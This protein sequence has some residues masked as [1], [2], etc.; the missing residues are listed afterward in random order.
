MKIAS[1]CYVPPPG[2]G[3]SNV[4]LANIRRFKTT[5]TLILLSDHDHGE[6]FSTQYQK[7]KA[8]F[9]M[10]SP[11]RL[12]QHV[13]HDEQGKRRACAI[14]NAVF[15][16]AIKVALAMKVTHLLYLES[17]CRVGCDNWDA[18]IF[19]E[20]FKLPFPALAAGT[21]CAWNVPNGGLEFAR[22]WVDA[23]CKSGNK[24]PLVSYGAF[25]SATCQN[26]PSVFP[27]GAL[28]V[29]NMQWLTEC[30]DMTSLLKT[31]QGLAWDYVLGQKIYETFGR[32]TFRVLAHLSSVCS[33]YGE[34]LSTE[35]NRMEWLRRGDYAAVHPVKS[36]A[37]I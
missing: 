14:S 19:D 28:G 20:Y 21:L 26:T 17:D 37:T 31:A 6:G 8:G 4:F 15:H 23:T 5:H 1:I 34:S 18:K 2:I 32:D 3:C 22:E 25:P 30:F 16:S 33:T 35:K 27:N 7:G 29:Y 13:L 10:G 24:F 12:P 11:E 9:Q 36:E